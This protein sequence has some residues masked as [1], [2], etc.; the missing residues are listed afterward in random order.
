MRNRGWRA[1]QFSPRRRSCSGSGGTSNS[2]GEITLQEIDDPPER[3]DQEDRHPANELQ[4]LQ[5]QGTTNFLPDIAMID[6]SNYPVLAATNKL[7]IV[8]GVIQDV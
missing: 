4:K 1:R 5:A 8:L 2:G 6:N 7:E 3:H